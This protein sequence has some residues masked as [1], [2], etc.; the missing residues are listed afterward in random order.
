M[1]NTR[2]AASLRRTPLPISALASVIAVTLSLGVAQAAPLADP[3]LRTLDDGPFSSF[4]VNAAGSS[5]SSLSDG[6]RITRA[7]RDPVSITRAVPTGP[8]E[9]GAHRRVRRVRVHDRRRRWFPELPHRQQL[10]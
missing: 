10:P 1:S 8:T 2:V 9:S 6:L 5:S 7:A 4:R 3:E